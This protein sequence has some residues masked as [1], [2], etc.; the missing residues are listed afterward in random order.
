[1]LLCLKIP[2][3]E[4]RASRFPGFEFTVKIGRALGE[5]SGKFGL[6][7]SFLITFARYAT[8]ITS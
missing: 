5:I 8:H 4:H 3:F 2:A 1:M 7:L 6:T